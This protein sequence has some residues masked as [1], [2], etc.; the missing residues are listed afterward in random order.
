MNSDQSIVNPEELQIKHVT[1]KVVGMSRLLGRLSIDQVWLGT[2]TGP[3]Y[4]QFTKEPPIDFRLGDCIDIGYKSRREVITD[5]IPEEDIVSI[6]NRFY[7]SFDYSR[8]ELVDS[9]L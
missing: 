3:L 8:S 1:G 4:I 9:I 6:C 7:K 2:K 5:N